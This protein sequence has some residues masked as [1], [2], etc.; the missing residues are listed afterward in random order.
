MPV[1]FPQLGLACL[2]T[3]CTLLPSGVFNSSCFSSH[4]IPQ[5]A[6]A[7]LVIPRGGTTA[8]SQPHRSGDPTHLACTGCLPQR[9]AFCTPP[10]QCQHLSRGPPFLF[11]K[12][13]VLPA[14]CVSS[15]PASAHSACFVRTVGFD[16]VRL[17]FRVSRWLL[18]TM[19]LQMVPPGSFRTLHSIWRCHNFHQTLSF[20]SCGSISLPPAPD[21]W[22]FYSLVGKVGC[23]GL[24]EIRLDFQGSLRAGPYP[25]VFPCLDS[26]LFPVPAE[27]QVLV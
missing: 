11:S 27:M 1:A 15:L 13:I 20:G 14:A 24:G 22:V 8:L 9:G 7:R 6:A 3:C 18:S 10:P 2:S 16:F 25:S 17:W 23:V 26:S 12:W 21:K 19:E 5:L 4:L